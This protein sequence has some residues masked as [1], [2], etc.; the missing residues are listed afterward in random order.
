MHVSIDSGFLCF[1]YM[2]FLFFFFCC[3]R[4][5]QPVE[6]VFYVLRTCSDTASHCDSNLSHKHP[7]VLEQIFRQF[8]VHLPSD[9]RL[10]HTLFSFFCKLTVCPG[11][12]HSS[13]F[14]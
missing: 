13:H 7:G 11:P 6:A 5:C 14:N 3:S 9:P 4:T 8:L 2:Y 10:Q 1:V 12:G